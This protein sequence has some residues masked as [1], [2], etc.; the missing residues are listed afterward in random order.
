MTPLWVVLAA[1][2][3]LSAYAA[4]AAVLTDDDDR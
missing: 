2:I 1:G 4:L 3:L